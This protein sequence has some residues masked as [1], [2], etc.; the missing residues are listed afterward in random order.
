MAFPS[1]Q[2][3]RIKTR[4]TVNRIV[5][6]LLATIV[7]ASL[8]A[9]GTDK[10]DPTPRPRVTPTLVTGSTLSSPLDRPGTYGKLDPSLE[11]LL[12]GVFGLASYIAPPR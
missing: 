4:S 3:A 11:E 1:A 9:C 12:E 7:I 8:V 2:K 5:T 10:P 6:A